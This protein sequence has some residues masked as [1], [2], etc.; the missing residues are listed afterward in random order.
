MSGFLEPELVRAVC[1]PP[2]SDP[3]QRRKA[4]DERGLTPAMRELVDSKPKAPTPL[5]KLDCIV[6]SRIELCG[7]VGSES[8]WNKRRGTVTAKHLS[9]HPQNKNVRAWVL[10][11]AFD[12]PISKTTFFSDHC[13]LL[14]PNDQP[15]ATSVPTK[16]SS[17]KIRPNE[18]CPCGSGKKFK[19]MLFKKEEK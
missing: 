18:K 2:L 1:R 6:G 5:P 17:K 10:E 7:L 13:R 15:F 8:N 16:T 9:M 19:K 11:I 3:N 12:K 14:S 4:V